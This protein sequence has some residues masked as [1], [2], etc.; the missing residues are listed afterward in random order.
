M[1]LCA[2]VA[3]KKC[4]NSSFVD[5]SSSTDH[6]YSLMSNPL[7]VLAIMKHC[8]LLSYVRLIIAPFYYVI[9]GVR[10]LK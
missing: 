5:S 1:L 8:N 10:S 6:A 9:L 3:Q 7:T 2:T 4:Y